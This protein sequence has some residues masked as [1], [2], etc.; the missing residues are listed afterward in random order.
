MSEACEGCKGMLASVC[1]VAFAHHEHGSSKAAPPHDRIPARG[2]QESRGR[3]LW[4]QQML[5]GRAG[6]GK[7]VGSL[8]GGRYAKHSCPAGEMEVFPRSASIGFRRW[9]QHL[10][11]RGRAMA[12]EGPT[13]AGRTWKGLVFL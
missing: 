2:R 10:A 12:K 6:V 13:H 3:V 1:G 11:R 8:P 5:R 4:G 9:K 7:R